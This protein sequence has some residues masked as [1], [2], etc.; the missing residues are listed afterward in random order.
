M[1]YYE[2]KHHIGVATCHDMEILFSHYGVFLFLD[3]YVKFYTKNT[4]HRFLKIL[5]ES[6]NVIL[7]CHT[8][9]IGDTHYEKTLFRAYINWE[10]GKKNCLLYGI[11]RMLYPMI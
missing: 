4:L 7:Y 8:T 2:N 3:A 9:N 6:K 11:L 1:T 10:E 5:S